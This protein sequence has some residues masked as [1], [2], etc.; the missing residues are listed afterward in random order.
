MIDTDFG[1]NFFSGIS[2]EDEEKIKKISE[3]TM[4]LGAIRLEM[5]NAGAPVK[6]TTEI[7]KAQER[8]EDLI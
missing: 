6:W 3:I 4:I 7:F 2:K 8:L 1:L 5:Q